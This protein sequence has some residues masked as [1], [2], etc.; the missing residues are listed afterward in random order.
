MT[1]NICWIIPPGIFIRTFHSL[2]TVGIFTALCVTDTDLNHAYQ[3]GQWLYLSAY[4]LL[5][6]LTSI[7]YFIS[8][9]LDPGYLPK[10]QY[11]V[12]KRTISLSS[13]SESS[14]ED[15]DEA[16]RGE[17][18]RMLRKSKRSPTAVKLRKCPICKIEQP[19]RT[20]HCEDC[21]RCVRKYDH[22][23]PW[24]E[25]CVGERNHRYFW[26]FL[27]L[28]SALILW[29]VR[30]TWGGF[31]SQTTFTEWLHSNAIFTLVLL[32]LLVAAMVVISLL[33]CHSFMLF[34]NQT[35]WEFMSRH[36]ITY[37]K[38]LDESYNPFHEGY[39]KNCIKF[40]FYCPYQKWEV[41]V[42]KYCT[43]SGGIV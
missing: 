23:C 24:L 36:R 43:P 7:F 25:N 42:E 26:I 33:C 19:V 28:Q 12:R 21:Q 9:L 4:L 27:L 6:I 29:T 31:T 38:N 18:A 32:I 14:D 2:L 39:L 35:T 5:L 20:K 41:M 37:L 17:D 15:E 10:Q 22:H 3:K 11:Q 13:S 1:D 34:N 40:F 16:S 8:C 30:I